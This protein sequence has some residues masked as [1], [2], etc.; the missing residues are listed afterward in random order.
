[1]NEAEPWI[2]ETAATY[3]LINP[4]GIEVWGY[5]PKLIGTWNQ[6]HALINTTLQVLIALARGG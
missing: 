6:L 4:S 2:T 1:M 3:L 5:I